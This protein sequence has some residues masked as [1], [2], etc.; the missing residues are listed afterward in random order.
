[1]V[2]E[3]RKAASTLDPR[4]NRPGPKHSRT[5][6]GS[7]GLTAG[8]PLVALAVDAE[9]AR[10]ASHPEQL[11]EALEASRQASSHWWY[12]AQFP[13]LTASNQDT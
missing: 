13:N 11:L 7:P 8:A 9:Q 6:L 3:Y 2:P 10:Q 5:G 4:K 1:M 12:R